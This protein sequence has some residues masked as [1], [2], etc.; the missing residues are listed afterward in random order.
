MK[1][2]NGWLH[3]GDIARVDEDGLVYIVDRKKD[4]IKYAGY[5]ISP[6]EIETVILKVPG[7]VAVCVT[8]IPV[9]GNDL[10]VALVVKALDSELTE[11]M[12]IDTVAESMVDFKH[13]RGGAYFVN[14]FPMTPSGKILRR[15]CRDI[16]VELY[17]ETQN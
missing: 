4:I 9:P 3:T 1:S 2:D 11:E 13:L 15:K 17:N 8:G 7:V 10:P 16:A 6:T 5:Q 14:A 12:I